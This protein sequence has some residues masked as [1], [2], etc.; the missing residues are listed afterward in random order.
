LHITTAM[1]S[2][3]N[4]VKE[5]KDDQEEQEAVEEG[6][7]AGGHEAVVA[8]VRTSNPRKTIG[9]DCDEMSSPSGCCGARATDFTIDEGF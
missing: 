7:K 4:Q 1:P 5:N 9:I 6:E 3:A 2:R 8:S